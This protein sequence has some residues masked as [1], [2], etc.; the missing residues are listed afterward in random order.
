M[1]R[2]S[3]EV[4]RNEFER[5]GGQV[6]RYQGD[7][8]HASIYDL[9]TN[10]QDPERTANQQN[11]REPHLR[12]ALIVPTIPLMFQWYDEVLKGN[13]PES[14][15]GLLGGGQRLKSLGGVRLLIAV[16]T[17]HGSGCQPWFARPSGPITCS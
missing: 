7:P 4:D 5:L 12:V 17:P 13:L 15:I 10:C 6:L 16:P 2:E 14:A 9:Y 3:R 1:N 11:E 8:V